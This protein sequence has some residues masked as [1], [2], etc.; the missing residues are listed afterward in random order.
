MGYGVALQ[1]GYKYAVQKG[2]RY[3][4]QM[5]GDGQHDPAGIEALLLLVRNDKTDLAL[6]SRF[7]GAG[8]YR[9]ST[10]RLLGMKFFRFLLFLLSGRRI[11]DTT[12]G[13]Q[14]MNRKVLK[15]FVSDLFPCDYP[16]ADVILLLSLFDLRIGEA[17]VTMYVNQYG[18]SMH[19]NPVRVLYYIFKMVMSL[20]LTKIRKYSVPG[21]CDP[22]RSGG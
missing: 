18:K 1:T 13:F 14:A 17:P 6:G 11:S 4:V 8:S 2:Y 15:L 19:R 10:I 12:T 9:P 7:L 21:M 22:E 3:L 5:D 16:D 20:L